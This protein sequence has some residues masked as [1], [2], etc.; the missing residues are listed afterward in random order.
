MTLLGNLIWF[1]FGGFVIGFA[2]ILVGLFFCLTIIGIPFGYQLMKIGVF[3]MFPFGKR[4]QFKNGD[5]GCISLIFN[6]L[7]IL[8]GGIWIAITHFILGLIFCI[9]IIGIPFGMQHFK[10]A[11]LACFPFGQTTQEK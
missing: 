5:M 8:L 11:K 7:W 10:L 1:I 3:S 4:P 9:T 2:Y 6:V